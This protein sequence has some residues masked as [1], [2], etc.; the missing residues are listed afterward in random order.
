MRSRAELLDECRRMV[1]Q[2]IESFVCA[3]DR[4]ER[5]QNATD[6][7][8]GLQE[9]ERAALDAVDTLH[10]GS[11]SAI[12]SN[13]DSLRMLTEHEETAA[14][15]L[16]VL[17]QRV[18]AADLEAKAAQG[19][20]DTTSKRAVHARKRRERMIR[21]AEE[22]LSGA[23]ALCASVQVEDVEM[24]ARKDNVWLREAE[25]RVC[26]EA[27]VKAEMAQVC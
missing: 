4:W 12:S 6:R 19:R 26:M 9:E 23:K 20:R 10:T 21:E 1:E 15:R 17:E 27:R 18:R 8:R 11:L 25:A 13:H 3:Y 22:R 14:Q 5:A 16:A 24:Q 2:A 7:V